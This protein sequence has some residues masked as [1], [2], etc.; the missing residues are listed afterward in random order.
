MASPITLT[1]ARMTA[2][3]ERS[4]GAAWG[5]PRERFEASVHESV[6]GAFKNGE[7]GADQVLRY[8]DALH[9]EDL[10]L[11]VACAEGLAPAWEHF[12]ATH[13][14]SLLRAAD[15]IDSSGGAR[16][17]ADSLFADLF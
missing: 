1:G 12:V 3:F 5:L 17:L 15:A 16:E 4:R 14:G 6:A 7:P 8:V 11:A 13:R 2:L 9:V 10:A